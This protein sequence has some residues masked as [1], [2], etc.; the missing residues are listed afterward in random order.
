MA[1]MPNLMQTELWMQE[2]ALIP[3]L[4]GCTLF[5]STQI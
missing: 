5:S 1:N 3:L 2:A 4:C